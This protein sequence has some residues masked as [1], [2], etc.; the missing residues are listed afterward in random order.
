MSCISW[1]YLL[2]SQYHADEASIPPR[3]SGLA[4]ANSKAVRSETPQ[5]WPS[6]Y[7]SNCYLVLEVLSLGALY[8]PCGHFLPVEGAKWSDP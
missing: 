4:S 3:P 5:R 2:S 8:L 7:N 6:F 1:L